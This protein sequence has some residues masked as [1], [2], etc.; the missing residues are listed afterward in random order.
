MNDV[1]GWQSSKHPVAGRAG[2]IKMNAVLI[3]SILLVAVICFALRR[4]QRKPPDDYPNFYF[5]PARSGGLFDDQSSDNA[6]ERLTSAKAE[7]QALAD[8]AALVARAAQGD[9]ETLAEAYASGDAALYGEVLDAL[10]ERAA[11]AQDLRSLASYITQSDRLRASTKLAAALIES[12]R[13]SPSRRALA[14][15]LHC[16]ALSDDPAAFQ[17]AVETALEYW[18]D[19]RLSR[20]SAE[21][22]RE[23]VES[24]YWMLGPEARRSGAGFVLKRRLA[25]VRRELATATQRASSSP[26]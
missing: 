19:G 8:R 12:W 3:I 11:T 2:R 20:L 24:S 17:R 15:V 4:W 5:E 23:L 14:D 21:E 16:A 1:P 9:Q 25:V 22:L 6:N 26:N 13:G 7:G 18:R 10:V